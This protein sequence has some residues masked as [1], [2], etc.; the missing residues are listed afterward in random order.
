MSRARCKR[1]T[2]VASTALPLRQLGDQEADIV[3][4]V[5]PIT[6]Y[7]V[8]ITDPATVRYHLEKAVWLA[9]HGRPGPVWIDVPLDVQGAE[10]DPDGRAA[11]IPRTEEPGRTA[12]PRRLPREG[13]GG[14]L[15][16]WPPVAPAA[17]ADG[18]LRGAFDEEAARRERCETLCAP[19]RGR[20]SRDPR[21]QR[22]PVGRGVP[23]C[24]T[25]SSTP[26]ASRS[27]RPGTPAT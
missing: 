20:A 3:R 23:I 4:L 9:T 11:S 22:H 27:A 14:G 6:K 5:S 24:S 16:S 2:T 13:A 25:G 17:Q 18:A 26:S 12:E 21:R 8:S 15:A 7:A 19:E 10:V 1:E